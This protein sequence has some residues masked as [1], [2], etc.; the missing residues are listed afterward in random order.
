MALFTILIQA[1]TS[2]SA[3]AAAS[4]FSVFMCVPPYSKIGFA[5]CPYA[6]TIAGEKAPVKQSYRRYKDF[7]RLAETVRTGLH[8]DH[9]L[10][11]ALWENLCYNLP[12]GSP[13]Y[14][15]GVHSRGFCF[16]GS[17]EPKHGRYHGRGDT[18]HFSC[19]CFP[20]D[21]PP[22]N[23]WNIRG[24]SDGQERLATATLSRCVLSSK[25]AA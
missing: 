10:C 13:Y 25:T 20:A 12:E 2:P 9:F 11:L 3:A 7:F 5:A 19:R 17:F 6:H 14:A 22:E 21:F 23:P 15:V 8:S 16:R 4:T 1:S 18:V 24:H